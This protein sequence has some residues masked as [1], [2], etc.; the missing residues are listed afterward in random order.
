ML[1]RNEFKKS[2][3]T[4]FNPCVNK[5]ARTLIYIRYSYCGLEKVLIYDFSKDKLTIPHDIQ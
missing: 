4:V 3:K 1:S 5:A 2:S